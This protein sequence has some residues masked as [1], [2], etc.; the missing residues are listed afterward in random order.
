MLIPSDRLNE[1]PQIIARL[2]KGERIDHFETIRQRKD[3][4]LLDI[5]LTISPV[6]DDKG[7]IVGASKIARDITERHHAERISHLLGARIYLSGTGCPAWTLF[8]TRR[9]TLCRDVQLT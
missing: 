3:A 7:K 9:P 1:E 6:R 5:S 4:S 8:L 2:T